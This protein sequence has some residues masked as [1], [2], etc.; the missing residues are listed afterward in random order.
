MRFRISRAAMTNAKS[1]AERAAKAEWGERLA[2][3]QAE[4][5]EVRQGIAHVRRESQQ[6]LASRQAEHDE[7]QRKWEDER[8]ALRAQAARL[9]DEMEAM[10]AADAAA[11]ERG[12]EAA[13]FEAKLKRQ[14]DRLAARRTTARCGRRSGALSARS[15]TAATRPDRCRRGRG[16]AARG[17]A[18]RRAPSGPRSATA[19]T[20]TCRR[21]APRCSPPSTKRRSPGGARPPPTTPSA[22]R[23][24]SSASSRRSPRRTFATSTRTPRSRRPGSARVASTPYATAPP[25]AS[26]AYAS[27]P[28]YHQRQ[29]PAPLYGGASAYAALGTEGRGYRI[30]TVNQLYCAVFKLTPSLP[31]TMQQPAMPQNNP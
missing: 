26:P 23:W 7:A 8:D 18:R 11:A 19:R 3:A 29:S 1:E 25:P 30:S 31:A 17:A 24:S 22:S 4:L 20:A 6:M 21:R 13:N 15:C 9:A 16:L 27:L 28:T 10:R 14:A 12:A 5:A 2:A